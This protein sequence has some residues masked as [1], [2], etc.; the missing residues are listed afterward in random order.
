MSST[1]DIA[2]QMLGDPPPDLPLLVLTN[3]QTAGRGQRDRTWW[4]G[5]GALTFSWVPSFGLLPN[6]YFISLAAAMTVVLA[7]DS[8]EYDLDSKIKWPNDVYVDR[9]KIAGIL[10]ESVIAGG[11]R[12]LVFG[13]GVNANNS[14]ADAP[15]EIKS[16]ATSLR[17][18]LGRRVN[19][20]QLLIAIIAQLNSLSSQMAENPDKIIEVCLNRSIW[21]IGDLVG[22][23]T[24]SGEIQGTFA[25]FGSSG[26]L[27]L[28]TNESVVQITSGT[29]VKI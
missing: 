8:L 19:L 17:D 25:G 14:L 20:N 10:I 4:A 21:E 11:A 22:V 2:R 24:H 26:Q 23:D 5:E 27:L 13:I 6:R 29:I 18:I 28:R 9:K 16:V 7:L 1:S 15:P 3:R 12:F